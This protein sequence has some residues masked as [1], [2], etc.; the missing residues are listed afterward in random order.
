MSRLF[1]RVVVSLL[2]VL[3][4][5]AGAGAAL[6][7]KDYIGFTH[8][9]A[10]LGSS[11]TPTGAGVK[12]T[13][14]EADSTQSNPDYYSYLPD[15]SDSHF[16]GKNFTAHLVYKN[17]ANPVVGMSGHANTVAHY[18]YGNGYIAP[19]IT[20]ITNYLADH[21][22]DYGFLN[23]GYTA[24]PL[25]TS[26]RVANHSWAGAST[27]KAVNVDILK[28]LDWVI[29]RDEYI[30][31]VGMYN[32][33]GNTTRPLLGSSFNAIAVGLSD[34]NSQHGS[35]ALDSLYTTGRTRPDLV[36]PTT[37]TSWATPMV[38]AAA[39]LLVEVG[40]KNP[41]RSTDPAVQYTYDRNGDKI[42]NAERSEVVKAALMAGASRTASQLLLGY[43]A[44]TTNGLDSTYG[45]GQLNIYNSYHI[46]AAG[47]QNSRQDGGIGLISRYG[48]DYD[49]YF[50]GLSNSN[51]TA[52]YYF[53]TLAD[54]KMTASLVWNLEVNGGTPDIFD[55]SA[56]FYHLGLYLYDLSD[57][58]HPLASAVG[59]ADNTENLWLSLHANHNYLLQ[60]SALTAGNF[61][62]DYGLA[63]EIVPLPG[64][65]YL[66]GAGVLVLVGFR[67]KFTS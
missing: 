5:G 22:L 58:N 57:L 27:A 18:F 55:G 53:T 50:G 21:W 52:S 45:A 11:N 25:T 62:W 59:E 34:G 38:S 1:T 39:A 7:Y 17:P 13:Q 19:G 32:G 43:H 16:S 10:E 66:L 63:W 23:N 2:L 64:T 54:G 20:S 60:V 51:R 4:W 29:H 30:Q 48:F 49:P 61:L 9:K 41:A 12:V 67:R 28:R 56:T 6:D 15:F 46:I 26:A 35:Y 3:L 8:L 47:E 31:V 37:A 44:T 36:A 65:V 24:Q 33:S 40:H 14:V 42:Y